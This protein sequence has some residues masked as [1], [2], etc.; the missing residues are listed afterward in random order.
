MMS[1]STILIIDDEPGLV[2]LLKTWLEEEDYEVYATTDSAEGLRLFFQKRPVLTLTDLRMPGMDGFQLIT[3]IREMS[4]SHVLVLTALEGEEHMVRGL[5]LGADS[6]LVKP[7]SKGALLA[8]VRALIRRATQTE[9]VATGYSDDIMA[10]NFQTH[11]AKIRGRPVDLTT[12]EFRLLAFLC[13]NKE[14]LVNRQEILD[15]VWGN[16]DGSL[17]SL[18][19][20]VHSLR[21]KLEED[22][23]NPRMILTVRGVGYR[24]RPEVNE[25]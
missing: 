18:K 22:P 17:N 5:G 23:S 16:P 14:R 24:Y 8:S 9:G 19:W 10:L 21:E 12:T 25:A 6:F 4:D 15:K 13:S 11:E 1:Q 20:F 7:V 3:R 2:D